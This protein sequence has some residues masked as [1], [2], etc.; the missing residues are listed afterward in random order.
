[1]PD[2]D[3][4]RDACE[5]NFEA[6]QRDCSGFVKAVATDLGVSISRRNSEQIYRGA[7]APAPEGDA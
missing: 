3:R 2:P 6:H 4:V 7:P 1:M 5:A